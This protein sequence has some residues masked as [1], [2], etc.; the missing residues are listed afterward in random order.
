[1]PPAGLKAVRSYAAED[2]PV[3]RPPP[4]PLRG[5]SI[6]ES[7]SFLHAPPEAPLPSTVAN[8]KLLMIQGF[9]LSGNIREWQLSCIVQ[10]GIVHFG[11]DPTPRSPACSNGQ[12]E[13]FH[14]KRC[15]RPLSCFR[16][17]YGVPFSRISPVHFPPAL[18]DAMVRVCV[19][20]WHASDRG[21]DIRLDPASTS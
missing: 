15:L 12:E 10:A 13:L 17:D 3:A 21:C 8:R 1:M 11:L 4:C 7:C 5:K 14:G 20:L 9:P 16:I 2:V 19:E 6:H 18:E